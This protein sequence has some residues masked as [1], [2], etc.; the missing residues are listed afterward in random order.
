MSSLPDKVI[1]VIL[2][3]LEEATYLD[4]PY[5]HL[6]KRMMETLFLSFFEQLE[7]LFKCEPLGGHKP[8][9]PLA[10]YF[11]FPALVRRKGFLKGLSSKITAAKSDINRQVLS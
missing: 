7:L 2:D 10:V 8:S 4:D 11:S 1:G 5:Q 3:V 6:K 9:Q